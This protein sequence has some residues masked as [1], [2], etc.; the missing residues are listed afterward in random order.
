[1]VNLLGGCNHVS[2]QHCVLYQTGHSGIM[3]LVIYEIKL[4]WLFVV[5]DCLIEHLRGRKSVI[6]K[7]TIIKQCRESFSVFY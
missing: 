1:M 6:Q 5:I 7:G 4:V 2:T 3:L